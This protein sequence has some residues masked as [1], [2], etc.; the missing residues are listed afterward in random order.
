M[1]SKEETIE[2]LLDEMR[3]VALNGD[4]AHL[5][6]L[7]NALRYVATTFGFV[8]V[9]DGVYRCVSEEGR[10]VYELTTRTCSC[11]GFAK[12]PFGCKHILALRVALGQPSGVPLRKTPYRSVE[13]EDQLI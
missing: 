2:R 9:E 8:E 1:L 11:P 12:T 3:R 6:Y 10:G 4:P 13:R 7:S 5:Q